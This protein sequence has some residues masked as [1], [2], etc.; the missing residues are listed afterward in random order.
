MT[1]A[2]WP[3]SVAVTTTSNDGGTTGP[4]GASMFTVGAI[5]SS[6]RTPMN[7]ISRPYELVLL[8]P[9][10]HA[11]GWVGDTPQPD[12]WLTNDLVP[13]SLIRTY[14]IRSVGSCSCSSPSRWPTSCAIVAH[15]SSSRRGTSLWV[16]EKLK[17]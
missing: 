13:E 4:P 5:D 10:L 7:D 9:Q 8:P 2:I 3:L 16:S 15:S 11:F 17:A 12:D 1:S 14:D 6:V